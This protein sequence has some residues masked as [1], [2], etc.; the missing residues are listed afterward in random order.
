MTQRL[1]PLPIGSIAPNFSVKNVLD[2]TEEE[3]HDIVK[4]YDGVLVNFFR[5]E[6]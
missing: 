3:L 2:D 4:Q 5:G 1:Q 6:F